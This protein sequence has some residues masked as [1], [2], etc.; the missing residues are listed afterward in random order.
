MQMIQCPNCGKLTGFKRALGFG[1][2]FMVLITLG[3]WMLVIPFYPA[4]CINCGLTRHSAIMHHFLVWYRN[5]NRVSKTY[6]IITP[7]LLLF[8]LGIFNALKS[9]TWHSPARNVDNNSLATNMTPTDKPLAPIQKSR[10]IAISSYRE[11]I[12]A[13]MSANVEQDDFSKALPNICNTEWNLL[14]KTGKDIGD[15][16]IQV[17]MCEYETALHQWLGE[18]VDIAAIS[19][20]VFQRDRRTN[21]YIANHHDEWIRNNPPKRAESYQ[22]P[23]ETESTHGNLSNETT[24]GQTSAKGSENVPYVRP[25]TKGMISAVHKGQSSTVVQT[26]LG[27]PVSVTLG[28]KHIYSYPNLKVV[29]VDGKVSEIIRSGP[30]HHDLHNEGTPTVQ[31]TFAY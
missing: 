4:R 14:L 17:K 1:T 22:A 18:K 10:N 5:L 19:M 26:I 13:C 21:E 24:T 27:P 3:L 8:G 15:S 12:T 29:F 25:P 6:L 11:F 23:R 30:P 2:F 9:A 31:S 20:N 28:A 7:F 16:E